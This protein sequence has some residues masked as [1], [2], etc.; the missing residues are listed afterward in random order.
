[1]KFG[2]I[3]AQVGILARVIA[4][5]VLCNLAF[6]GLKYLSAGDPA[7]VAARVHS[8]FESGELVLNDYLSADTRRGMH[9]YNDCNVL[10][11]LSNPDA[12]RLKRALA[13]VIYRF[14]PD[15]NAA[16]PVLYGV[17]VAG[18]EREELQNFR[19]GRYWHGYNAVSS[20]LLRIVELK[21][22]RRIFVVGAWLAVGALLWAAARR[23]GRLRLAGLFSGISAGL[24]WALPNFAPNIT[25]GPGDAALLLGLAVPILKPGLLTNPR[26][27]W[28]YGAVYGALMVFFEA[29]VG[30]LPV[31][32]AWLAALVLAANSDAPER[33]GR[34]AASMVLAGLA[35]F[36]LGAALT[37]LIKQT[38]AYGFA[39]PESGRSFM[40]QLRHYTAIPA[41]RDG[42]PGWLLPYVRLV[43]SSKVLAYGN[44]LAG[45]L[46]VYASALAWLAAAVRAWQRRRQP[47]GFEMFTLLLAA[48]IPAAWVT[49]LMQHTVYHAPF[50]VRMLVVL[51]S[52]APLALVWPRR[53]P[54][55]GQAEISSFPAT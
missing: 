6:F 8:A 26:W 53:G 2:R 38:L 12:D 22:M 20:I 16:C 9:Q 24:F 11:M 49:L 13:P 36:G 55:A 7:L 31:A 5:V 23:K 21:H 15:F 46:L 51:I 19:Y 10:Q 42:W 43:E 34:R 30:L 52:L 35:A 32:G 44:D 40:T 50:M 18:V 1:M 28:T 25:H 41:G 45:R 27:L 33:G 17:V 39:E 37:V 3:N 48:L 47:A 4:A 29:L 54:H 14:D